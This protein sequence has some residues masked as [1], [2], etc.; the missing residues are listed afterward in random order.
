VKA[1]YERVMKTDVEAFR[2]MLRARNISNAI[3]S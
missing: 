2:Q 3:I 1:L